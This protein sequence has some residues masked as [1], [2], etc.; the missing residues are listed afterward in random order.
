[1]FPHM[2][3]INAM[4][5][6]VFIYFRARQIWILWTWQL[7]YN[8]GIAANCLWKPDPLPVL[9]MMLYLSINRTVNFDYCNKQVL[10][11]RWGQKMKIKNLVVG[12]ATGCLCYCINKHS[13]G[14]LNRM[15]QRFIWLHQCR[16]FINMHRSLPRQGRKWKQKKKNIG[17]RKKSKAEIPKQVSVIR[18]LFYHSFKS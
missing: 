6:A 18:K 4:L 2:F 17:E 12:A 13:S 15:M 16:S 7:I 14:E 8:N 5:A 9:V 1:M 3:Y 10:S 11:V